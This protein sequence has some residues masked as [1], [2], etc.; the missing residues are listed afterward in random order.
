METGSKILT[1]PAKRL[2]AILLQG[3]DNKYH[4][5]STLDVLSD[6]FGAN[7][8]NLIEVYSKYIGLLELIA[9]TENK[10][11]TIDHS[12]KRSFLTFIDPIRAV[13]KSIDPNSIWQLNQQN[14]RDLDLAMLE[15]AGDAL[16][17]FQPE[18]LIEENELEEI[19]T[20]TNDLKNEVLNSEI[21]I[22]LKSV[23]HELLENIVR[24][25]DDYQ[26]NGAEGLKRSLSESYGRVLVD[27]EIVFPEREKPIIKKF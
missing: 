25:I 20:Q 11:K 8:N 13:L 19:K 4:G 18:A 15:L 7:K 21:S 17:E 2:H 16:D 23:I 1:N 3:R 27:K 22:D 12:Q 24:S 14:P 26:I 9:H 6:L 5:Q 10:L